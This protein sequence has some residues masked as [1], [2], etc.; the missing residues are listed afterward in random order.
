MSYFN[1]LKVLFFASVVGI[2]LFFISSLLEYIELYIRYLR[3]CKG[4]NIKKI[5]FLKFVITYRRVNIEVKLE[6]DLS[7]FDIVN[8]LLEL[9]PKA[10]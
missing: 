10:K 4:S 9:N 8:E 2:L 3:H 5:H 1:F 6:G 7:K